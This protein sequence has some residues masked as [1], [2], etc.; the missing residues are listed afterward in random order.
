MAAPL[1]ACTVTPQLVMLATQQ[2]VGSTAPTVTRA[3]AKKSQKADTAVNRAGTPQLAMPLHKVD[4]CVAGVIDGVDG[5]GS[6]IALRGAAING[7]KIRPEVLMRQLA[8]FGFRRLT[9]C[10]N[11]DSR[12][13]LKGTEKFFGGSSFADA[14]SVH[15][16][17]YEPKE[18]T[19]DD[20]NPHDRPRSEAASGKFSSVV[21][22]ARPKISSRALVRNFRR[23]V[24]RL[25]RAKPAFG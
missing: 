24:P 4:A 19:R 13:L 15:A 14:S 6:T 2:E 3:S 9:A 7:K 25:G 18:S 11:Q 5:G 8:G 20:M 16:V 17:F 10:R 1:N 23:S 12:G 22:M 21:K